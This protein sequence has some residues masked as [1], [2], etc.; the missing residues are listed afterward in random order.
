MRLRLLQSDAWFQLSDHTVVVSGPEFVVAKDGVRRKPD[1]RFVREVKTRRQHADNIQGPVKH[2]DFLPQRFVR[3][4]IVTDR[5]S[6]ADHRCASAPRLCF[7]S[8]EFAANRR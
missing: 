2:M 7:V 3:V 6:G 4:A 5:E 1:A 8:V